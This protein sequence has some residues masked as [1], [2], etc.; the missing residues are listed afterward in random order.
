MVVFNILFI[1]L[2]TH[3]VFTLGVDNSKFSMYAKT[4]THIL[5]RYSLYHHCYECVKKWL[6]S[7]ESRS[8][9]TP[10]LQNNP[11]STL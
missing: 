3:D 7:I 2:P 6:R 4:W 10:N 11:W 9:C 1:P 8:L 5:Y